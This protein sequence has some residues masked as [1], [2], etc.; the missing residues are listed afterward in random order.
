MN[1]GN[2]ASRN[3]V[4]IVYASDDSFAE[5]LG[6]SLV[7]LFENSKD[8]EN[9]HIYILDADISD[10]NHSR[11][12]EVFNTYN[13]TPPTWIKA[14]NITE[15]LGMQVAVDRGSLSQYARLFISRDL[16]EGL[17]SRLNNK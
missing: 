17:S 15:E 2:T 14:R 1:T 6:V 3:D 12:E 10:L 16:P 9:I 11:I 8:V 7:S 4:H 5:V 13:R